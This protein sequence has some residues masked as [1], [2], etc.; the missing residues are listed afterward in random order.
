[1]AEPGGH[2]NTRATW[3]RYVVLSHAIVGLP[4]RDRRTL[5]TL[6]RGLVGEYRDKSGDVF[7]PRYGFSLGEFAMWHILGER[8]QAETSKKRTMS[9]TDDAL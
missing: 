7:F 6:A 9:G 5:F 3:E 1:M 2:V 4:V 8:R